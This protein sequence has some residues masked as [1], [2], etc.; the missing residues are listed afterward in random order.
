MIFDILFY[1]S[2]IVPSFILLEGHTKVIMIDSFQKL[3]SKARKKCIIYGA[4]TGGS[5]SAL[6]FGALFLIFK[7]TKVKFPWYGY[8]LSALAGGL[9]VGG[10]LLLALYPFT[11]R[12]AK[13]LDRKYGLGEKV[14]TMVEFS[15]KDSAV[16]QLQREQTEQAL[17]AI[18]SSKKGWKWALKVCLLPVLAA[19]TLTTSLVIPKPQR[20]PPAV[21]VPPSEE[22]PFEWD[23]WVEKDL[24]TLIDNVK[25]STL[26]ERLKPAYV[27]LLEELLEKLTAETPPT[28]KEMMTAVKGGMDLLL[29]T[30]KADNTYNAY[31]AAIKENEANLPWTATLRTALKE[32]GKAYTRVDGTDKRRFETVQACTKIKLQT[33][34]EISLTTYV[35]E[36]KDKIKACGYQAAYVDFVN[37]YSEELDRIFA[38]EDVA[39]LAADEGIKRELV[40]LQEGLNASVALFDESYSLN[41]VIG[42][43]NTA[44]DTFIRNT[45]GDAGVILP[46]AEQANTVMIKDYTFYVLSDLFGVAIPNEDEEDITSNGPETT[47]P[48]EDEY[49][50]DGF[51]LDPLTNQFV[52]YHDLISRYRETI[53]RLLEEDALADDPQMT[54]EL[55]LQIKAFLTALEEKK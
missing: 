19:A 49:L 42:K 18:P 6:I 39:N 47:P 10:A 36:V 3:K 25:G 24:Q 38:Y 5:V 45:N 35:D 28:Q 2:V 46:L 52:S 50:E 21:V 54:K 48:D 15:K 11:K 44:F 1:N 53:N 26:T 13:Q 14:Q 30:T 22:E 16:L 17:Q 41:A 20:T 23:E 31:A 55:E 12:F 40:V 9:L 32:S 37:D 34:V 43:A 29:A 8:A 7:L 33:A 27:T 51:I 4:V